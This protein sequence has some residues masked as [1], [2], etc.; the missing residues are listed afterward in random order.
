VNPNEGSNTDILNIP[1]W[2]MLVGAFLLENIWVRI[3]VNDSLILFSDLNNELHYQ[4]DTGML[5]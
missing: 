2:Q 1:V 5:W 4:I 3:S